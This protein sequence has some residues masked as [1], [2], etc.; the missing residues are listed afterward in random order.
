MDLENKYNKAI[1]RN[2]ILENELEGKNSLIEQVQRLKDELK[3]GFYGRNIIIISI[4]HYH[5]FGY[6][7]RMI[8]L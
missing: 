2:V 1:E 5:I 7:L 3:G 4:F 6:S 8:F